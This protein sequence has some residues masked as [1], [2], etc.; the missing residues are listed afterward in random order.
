VFL[1]VSASG[2]K[3]L[4]DTY[5]PGCKTLEVPGAIPAPAARGKSSRA[6]APAAAP[7]DFP[8]V[9]NAQQKARDNDRREILSEEL[10]SEQAKL[11]Q[12]RAEF[13]NGEP[14]RNGNERNYAKYQERVAQMRDN[15]A[16]SEKNIEALQREIASIK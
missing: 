13:K 12:L 2:G 8:K 7:A 6:A 10:R 5:K 11:D 15:I 9:G 16:R 4:T 3:E 14:D 1:C